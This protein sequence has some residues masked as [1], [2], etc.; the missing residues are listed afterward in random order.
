M[1]EEMKLE[2]IR[3]SQPT[4]NPSSGKLAGSRALNGTDQYTPLPVLG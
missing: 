4:I 1:N 2:R 3:S